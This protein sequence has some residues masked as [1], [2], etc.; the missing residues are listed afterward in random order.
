MPALTIPFCITAS[1]LDRSSSNGDV[2]DDVTVDDEDV[3][4]LAGLQR[5][6]I[7]FCSADLR[8]GTGGTND[9]VHRA[10]ADVVD[11]EAELFGVVTMRVPREA[12]VAA[13]AQPTTGL[14]QLA[15][16]DRAGLE[17][18]LV[19]VDHPLREPELGTVVDRGELELQCRNT[20]NVAFD[21][22]VD[23]LVVEER[24]VLDR[25]VSG[26]QCVLDPL[27]RPAMAVHLAPVIVCHLT[28][29]L[30]LLEGHRQ[31]VVVIG[32]WCSSITGRIRLQP[33]GTSLDQSAGGTTLPGRH[34]RRR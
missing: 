25:V 19:A 14:E 24:A 31:G 26:Q 20:W 21:H 6:D 33:L 8:A 18:F 7:V 13:Q 11:E 1:N 16:A 2:G 9:G 28:D 32:V 29:R 27:G 10:E 17:R 3:G 30:H 22:H 15:G 12:V 4:Q 5:S 23:A 34:H